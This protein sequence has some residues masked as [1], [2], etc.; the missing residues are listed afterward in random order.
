MHRK[1]RSDQRTGIFLATL[2]LGIGLAGALM[3]RQGLTISLPNRF[4]D[5][6]GVAQFITNSN[7]V[8]G[9]AYGPFRPGQSP[10]TQIFPSLA[11]AEA[12]MP[13]LKAIANGIRT[14]GC[15]HL[16]TVITATAQA[17]LPLAQGIWLNSDAAANQREI[18][19]AVNQAA[20]HS[21]IQ[22]LVVGNET[23]LAGSLTVPQICQYLADVKTQS[24]LPVTTAE[25]WKVWIDHPDL[26]Q[27]VD[28]LSVNLYAFWDGQDIEDAVSYTAARY[29]DVL[30]LANG[31]PVILG[32]VGWPTAGTTRDRAIPGVAEQARF[33]AAFLAWAQQTG[34]S[35]YWFEA[36]DETWKCDRDRPDVEC[37]WGLYTAERTPKPARYD[38]GGS[39]MWLPLVARQPTPTATPAPTPTPTATQT[40]TPSP[41]PIPTATPTP[42]TEAP[43]CT[44]T[45]PASNSAVNTTGNCVITVSGM[46]RGAGPGGYLDFSIFT[47][48][49]YRQDPIV[50]A[51]HPDGV[52]QAYPIYLAGKSPYNNHQILGR[53]HN[54]GGTVVAN[55]QVNGIVRSN[56]CSTP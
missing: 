36:F 29:T 32:E 5:T 30:A 24:G 9:V 1:A 38:F 22:S 2:L 18:G 44:I 53:L 52:W 37:H 21:H 34:A 15:D 54:S 13:L 40:Q 11:D 17:N 45:W 51:P 8:R 43:N 27:C 48:K 20:A 42:T 7:P 10:E 3:S 4:N 55:C 6:L 25:P 31:K 47:D 39:R 12:D 28:Y 35:W 23:I 26:I 46:A 56:S 49:W 19:C 50:P 41:T 16:E 33:A 14:Y